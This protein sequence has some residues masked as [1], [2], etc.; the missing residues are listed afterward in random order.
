M[1]VIGEITKHYDQNCNLISVTD[2]A[3]QAAAANTDSATMIIT[4][5]ILLVVVI[6]AL[7][8][9]KKFREIHFDYA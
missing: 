4:I 3:M 2:P 6:A 8:I 5:V 1:Q 7:F 9:A